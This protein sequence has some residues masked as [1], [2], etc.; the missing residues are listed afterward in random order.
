[1]TIL[2]AHQFPV[3]S[4]RFNPCADLVVTG[5]A[6]NTVRVIKVPAA[7]ARGE[8]LPFFF[9]PL[10]LQLI[11]GIVA[12]NSA[13]WTILLTLL[14]LILAII[15]QQTATGGEFSVLAFY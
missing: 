1:M 11:L 15:L 5:S 3:T 8:L 2:Q 12:G 13:V 10:G 4:L 14:V 7:G 9:L 6:D